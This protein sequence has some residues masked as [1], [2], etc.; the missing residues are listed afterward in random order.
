MMIV[1]M[2]PSSDQVVLTITFIKITMKIMISIT[3]T[4]VITITIT[5]KI[6]ITITVTMMIPPSSDQVVLTKGIV[7]S[8]QSVHGSPKHCFPA[9]SS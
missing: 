1:I 3:I 2:L 6:T 9:E 5:M 8:P 7:A 4:I